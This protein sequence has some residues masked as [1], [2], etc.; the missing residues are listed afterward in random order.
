MVMRMKRLRPGAEP[1][2]RQ[3]AGSAGFDLK[4]CMEEPVTLKPGD[5]ST[6]CTGWAVEIPQ[7]CVGLVFCRSGLG[8]KHGVSLPN[9]VGVIDSDYRGELQVPPGELEPGALYGGAW[10]AHCPAGGC[11]GV[12]AR[13][14]GS[15]RAYP[16]GPGRGRV[17]QHGE[18]SFRPGKRGPA[19]LVGWALE[20]C[21]YKEKWVFIGLCKLSS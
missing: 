1:P 15:G 14:G 21:I 20:R 2:Q 6:F 5:R 17:W 8:A 9:C 18:M 10:R 3:T 16:N 11:A 7:G 4:A 13:G 12:P 19:Y